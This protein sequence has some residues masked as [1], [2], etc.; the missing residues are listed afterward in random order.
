L[1]T[2]SGWLIDGV[3]KEIKSGEYSRLAD[4]K[5]ALQPWVSANIGGQRV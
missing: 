5:R 1:R 4:T 2:S 3:P